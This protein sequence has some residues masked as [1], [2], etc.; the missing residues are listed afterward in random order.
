MKI[1]NRQLLQSSDISQN[2]SSCLGLF[3]WLLLRRR[4][5]IEIVPSHNSCISCRNAKLGMKIINRQL[6]QSSDISQNLSS[7][8][9]LFQWLLLRR[10]GTIEIVPSHNSRIHLDR[11]SGTRIA[12]GLCLY[13]HRHHILQHLSFGFCIHHIES[14]DSRG[15]VKVATCAIV[16]RDANLWVTIIHR[17]L[18]Q[19]LCVC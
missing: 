12:P 3:Q 6:L 5:T 11:N 15:T 1:I 7:C 18:F 16:T 17:Q 13:L 10:R 2:L 9:G 8:L 19:G 14:W 4:G